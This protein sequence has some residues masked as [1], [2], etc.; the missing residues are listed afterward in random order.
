ME[1]ELRRRVTR[2]DALSTLAGFALSLVGGWS[3]LQA[4]RDV[5]ATFTSLAGPPGHWLA[6]TSCSSRTQRRSRLSGSVSW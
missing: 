6:A 2:R 5:P 1:N 4:A 3:G